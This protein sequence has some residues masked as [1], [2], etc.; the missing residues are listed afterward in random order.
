[1]RYYAL[2][3]ALLAMIPLHPSIG[4]PMR[5]MSLS[6]TDTAREPNITTATPSPYGSSNASPSQRPTM[7]GG[8][9]P[10]RGNNR[11]PGPGMGTVHS[12]G[13]T[14]YNDTVL[15]EDMQTPSA[16]QF[17]ESFCSSNMQPVTDIGRTSNAA[18]CMQ[19]TKQLACDMF[20]RLPKDAQNVL[21]RSIGCAYVLSEEE[22]D[23]EQTTSSTCN[24]YD[25]RRLRLLKKYWD[26]Q[27]TSYAL[28][29][30]PEMVLNPMLMCAPYR[31]AY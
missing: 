16:Y 22:A 10:L 31:G 15:D 20:S 4:A 25:S 1:M 28:A 6:V 21:D 27:E 18:D 19:N 12:P 14:L 17:M 24:K 8:N 5:D 11:L 7:G 3:S 26:D 13:T 23:A 29:F 9:Y 2:L 30:M